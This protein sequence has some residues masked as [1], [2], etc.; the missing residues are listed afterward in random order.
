MTKY[1]TGVG[2]R[3]TPA[4]VLTVM[5][6]FAGVM[7]RQGYTLRSGHAEG[8]DRAFERGAYVAGGKADVYLPWANFGVR[9]Y[10]GSPGAPVLGNAIVRPANELEA[11]YRKLVELG[12]R[13][14]RFTVSR[15]VRSIS[16]CAPGAQA[17]FS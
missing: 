4:D 9:D 8:A 7:A 10:K 17:P 15:T 13:N 11:N 2:S 1:W 16:S 6:R 5:E 14:R 12:I 3:A